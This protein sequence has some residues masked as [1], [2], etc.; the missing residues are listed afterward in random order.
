VVVAVQQA[1]RQWQPNMSQQPNPDT[2]II[3]IRFLTHTKCR[4]V[5]SEAGAVEEGVG[6]EEE[7]PQSWVKSCILTKIFTKCPRSRILPTQFVIRLQCFDVDLKDTASRTA[8]STNNVL[9][10]GKTPM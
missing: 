9:G 8:T 10:Q 6:E 7:D 4:G 2:L 5:A 3:L 1:V